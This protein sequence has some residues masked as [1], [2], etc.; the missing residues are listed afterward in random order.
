M[1]VTFTQI[2]LHY[3]KGASTV[4]VRRQSMVH[5]ATSLIQETWLVQVCI[6]G[7]TACE[8]LFK[9]PSEQKPRICIAI[10]GID[11][12]LIFNFCSRDL[13]AMEMKIGNNVGKKDKLK[14]K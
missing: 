1:A 12:R 8:R 9:S 11:T 14:I 7:L 4:L 3:S 2:N 6:R 5:T 13:V 10:K